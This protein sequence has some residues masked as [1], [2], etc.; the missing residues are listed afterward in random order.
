MNIVHAYTYIAVDTLPCSEISRVAFIGIICPK[1]WR[2]FEGG[3]N[4]GVVRY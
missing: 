3:D 1:V 2:D 4:W